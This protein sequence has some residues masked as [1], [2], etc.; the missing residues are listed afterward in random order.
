MGPP[1]INNSC[2]KRHECLYIFVTN[3][4]IFEHCHQRR[5]EDL[6]SELMLYVFVYLGP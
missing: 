6:G 4:K 1:A 2:T 5:H 3:Q